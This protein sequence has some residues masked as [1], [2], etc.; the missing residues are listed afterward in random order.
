MENRTMLRSSSHR[1]GLLSL[2]LVGLFGLTGSNFHAGERGVGSSRPRAAAGAPKHEAALPEHLG[3]PAAYPR[4]RYIV[5][6]QS[7][8]IARDAVAKAGGIV[9]SDL[10]IIRAVATTLDERQ[11]STLR[12]AN[13]PQLQIF[14]DSNV[15]ASSRGTLPETYYPSELDATNLHLGGMTGRGVTVAVIDSG[16]WNNQGP[17]QSAPGNTN[18]RIIAQ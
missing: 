11:V 18:S 3:D 2:R 16:L 12:A 13:V 1:I 15:V 14:E 17:L 10:S 7:T 9:S 8:D 5:Q 4:H 6:A